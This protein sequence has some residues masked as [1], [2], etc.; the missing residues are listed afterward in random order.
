MRWTPIHFAMKER[1][2][3]SM[4]YSYSTHGTSCS[5]ENNI[6]AEQTC[7]LSKLKIMSVESFTN[8]LVK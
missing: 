4:K 8:K 7:Q 3:K 6:L 1:N 5:E 2:K